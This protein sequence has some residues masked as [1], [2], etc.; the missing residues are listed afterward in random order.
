LL[1]PTKIVNPNGAL[2]D[3]TSMVGMTTPYGALMMGR[4]YTP[5]YEVIAMSDTFEAGT[6]A[7]WGNIT[8]GTGGFLTSGVALRANHSIQYRV[9]G[10][11][12]FGGAAMYGFSDTGALN[13]SDKFRGANLKYQKDGWNIGIGYNSENNPIGQ[14][15]LT[16]LVIGGSY[17]SG[18]IKTF[19][20]YLRMR[21]THSDL[22]PLLIPITGSAIATIVGD[23]AKLDARSYTLGLQYRIGSGRIMT[24]VG[25]TSNKLAPDANVTLYGL[26]YDYNL[27]KRTDLY[28][29]AAHTANQANAQYGLGGA[30]FAG[31]FTSA[32]GKNATA[33]QIGMR[34]RF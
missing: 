28:A 6:A 27:S 34:H 4:Q 33:F 1:Q 21:N 7:G 19:A 20:G 22:V 31:G 18:D 12:G 2:F 11:E 24:S 25:R 5:G 23:N 17:T 26:G 16:S 8:G 3:R 14:P 10:K 32:P 13:V 29:I 30:G 9:Q 15:S